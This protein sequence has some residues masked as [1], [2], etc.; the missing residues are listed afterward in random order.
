MLLSKPVA[1]L[2]F[3]LPSPSSLLNPN[4]SNATKKHRVKKSA[5]NVDSAVSTMVASAFFFLVSFAAVIRIVTRH[6]TLLPTSG[7]SGE[8]RCVTS[9]D[10]NNGCEG[11]YLFPSDQLFLKSL[12]ITAYN[13][14]Q[15]PL[16]IFQT[17][18]SGTHD[19][20]KI[21]CHMSPHSASRFFLT[22]CHVSPTANRDFFLSF[23]CV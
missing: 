11:D 1:F 10:P 16:L 2:P 21:S 17:T 9:D 23:F 22:S 5:L 7:I 12:F 15:R 4:Y 6:A 3:S 8:E 19:L 20:Q 18:Q 14:R 13:R